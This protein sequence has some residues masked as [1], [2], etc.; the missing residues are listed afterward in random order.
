MSEK[1]AVVFD[2]QRF[3]LNDGPGIRT[4]VFLKGCPL[5]CIWCHNPESKSQRSEL[6]LYPTKCIGCGD[7]VSSCPEGLHSFGENGQHII[8]REKCRRCGVC[9]S[10]CAGAIKLC[11]KPMSV[12]EALHQVMKDSVF[13]ANS[14]GGLTISGGEPLMQADFTQALLK[15]AKERGIHT[16]I[17]T[18]GYAKWDVIESL[19]DY[20]DLFLW[21]VKETDSKRHKQYTGVD[22]ALILSNLHRLNDL[23][24]TVVLRCPIIPGYNDRKEHLEA[25]GKMA[26]ELSCVERVD[27]EPYHPL[28]KSKAEALGRDYP[29][30]DLTFPSDEAVKSWCETV[31]RLTTKPVAKS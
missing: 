17:E 27:I 3:S 21:D 6:M 12:D 31:A 19:A 23:G 24:A 22:N 15:S 2:V 14:G 26:E 1:N 29:L 16:A 28:G 9:E 13:Y 20:V 10:A 30:D 8:A 5:N 4:I 11:G 7:C 25:I 18:S